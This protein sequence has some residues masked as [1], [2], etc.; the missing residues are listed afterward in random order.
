MM[1]KTA[2]R[3]H[4][5]RSWKAERYDR[6]SAWQI[7]DGFTRLATVTSG[8]H[9]DYAA[10]LARLIAAAPDLLAAHKAAVENCT[11]ALECGDRGD[12]ASAEIFIN[13]QRGVSETA[14]AKA[15]A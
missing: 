10:E 5:L 7:F 1:A 4:T 6:H 9:D 13:N 12:W 14:I 11:R 15:E 2:T 8:V 3:G